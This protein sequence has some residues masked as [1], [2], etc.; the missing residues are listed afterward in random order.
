MVKIDISKELFGSKG[1]FELKVKLLIPKGEFITIAGSS[2][3]G[4]ST[5]LKI[6]AGLEEAKGEIFVEQEC[7]L[8][9]RCFLKPQ[10]REVGFVFQD[11]A[12]FENMNILENLLFVS[13]DEKLAK[14]LLKKVELESLKMRYPKSLSGGQKQRVALAR[15]LMRKPKLLLMD[16]PLS[17]LDSQTRF[18]LQNLIKKLHEEFKMT[19]IMITHSFLDIYRLSDRALKLENGKVFESKR[20]QNKS[21]KLKF[22]AK[23]LDILENSLILL[24]CDEVFEIDKKNVQKI[25][26]IGEFLELEIKKFEL[27]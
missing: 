21:K 7:W 14:Y 19:T 16:E 11:Y 6:L 2:G 24:I 17:A 1:K 3:S 25:P 26:Q 12:L 10:K 8:K 4:K 13:K 18:K 9:E 15:A 5:F 27:F 23:V 22:N 20:F